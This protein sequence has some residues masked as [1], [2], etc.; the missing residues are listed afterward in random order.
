MQT[1]QRLPTHRVDPEPPTP[2]DAVRAPLGRR[3]LQFLHAWSLMGAGP[4]TLSDL[5]PLFALAPRGALALTIDAL[6]RLDCLAPHDDTYFFIGP[7]VPALAPRS[8]R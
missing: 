8:M 4:I 7:R 6:V 5:A 1:A 3:T 2:T